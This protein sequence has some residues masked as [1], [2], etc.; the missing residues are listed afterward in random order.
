MEVETNNGEGSSYHDDAEQSSYQDDAEQ[1][2]Y[3]EDSSAHFHED[4]QYHDNPDSDGCHETTDSCLGNAGACH[5]GECGDCTQHE[6][7]TKRRFSVR[8]VAISFLNF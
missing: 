3:H 4:E 1:S 8:Q 2:S 7:G 6:V 5:N